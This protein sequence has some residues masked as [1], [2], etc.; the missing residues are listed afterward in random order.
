M[1]YNRLIK[2][3]GLDLFNRR[4]IPGQTQLQSDFSNISKITYYV[5]VQN[6]IFNALQQ[7]LYALAFDDEEEDAKKQK[8]YNTANGMLDSILRGSGIAGVGA[9]TLLSMIRKVY[10]EAQK[11][12]T[13]PGPEYADAAWELLNFSPPIDIKASKLR[14]AGNNW[15]YEGWKHD[16]AQWGIDDPAYKSAA[17][18]I[19]ALTNVPIDRLFKKIDN[20]QGALDSQEETWKRISQALGWTKWQLE[21]QEDIKQHRAQEKPKKKQALKNMY[22][23]TNPEVYSKTE[24]E[25][26]LKK[27][28]Y[29]KEQIKAMKREEDRVKAILDKQKESG[30]VIKPTQARAYKPK[31][32]ITLKQ[33]E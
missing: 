7:A 27:H 20:I 28:G 22:G 25:E 33:I 15:K 14:I 9:S 3:A 13:F 32:L 24:Q 31:K 2:K 4:K 11:E 8:Y 1:Q 18:V 23:E 21:T 29:T 26:I 16:E 19:S 12:G 6:L 30:K 17:Y 5:A 10:K